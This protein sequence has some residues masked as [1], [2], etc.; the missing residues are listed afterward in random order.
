MCDTTS[1]PIQWRIL[2]WL[3]MGV[4][5]L[6]LKLKALLFVCIQKRVKVENLN[7]SLPPC[8]RQTASRSHDQTQRFVNAVRPCPDPSVFRLWKLRFM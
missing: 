2:D 8:L 5:G 3:K 4:W 7:D 6:A 1:I